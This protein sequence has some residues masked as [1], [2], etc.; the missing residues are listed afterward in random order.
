MREPISLR[1]RRCESTDHVVAAPSPANDRIVAKRRRP[2]RC[3]AQS[4]SR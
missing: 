2:E 4:M 3:S 1:R